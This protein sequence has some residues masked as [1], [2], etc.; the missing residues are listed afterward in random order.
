[1][2]LD[3]WWAKRNN[4]RAARVPDLKTPFDVESALPGT[5]ESRL[6]AC[7][8]HVHRNLAAAKVRAA[9]KRAWL[10]AQRMD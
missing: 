8:V 1:M 5:P 3:Y 9:H 7:F 2:S 4:R 10:A 6:A